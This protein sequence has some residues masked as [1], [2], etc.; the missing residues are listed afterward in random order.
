MGIGDMGIGDMGIG[1]MG[2]GDMG[3]GGRPTI[4]QGGIPGISI[5]RC[6]GLNGVVPPG[7]CCPGKGENEPRTCRAGCDGGLVV[8]VGQG[9][10]VTTCD[11]AIT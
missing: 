7:Y 11:A 10:P 1:D 3:I 6:G 8:S 9:A 5:C 2:I 4:G